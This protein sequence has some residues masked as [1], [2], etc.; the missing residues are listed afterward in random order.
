VKPRCQGELNENKQFCVMFQAKL[1]HFKLLYGA[2]MDG[3]ISETKIEPDKLPGELKNVEFVE[4]KTG[5]P[6]GYVHTL[7]DG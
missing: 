1:K 3:V 5:K 7:L 2:E 4:L 6:Y